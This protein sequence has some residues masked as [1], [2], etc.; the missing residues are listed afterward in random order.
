MQIH[1]E[2][3]SIRVDNFTCTFVHM[4]MFLSDVQEAKDATPKTKELTTKPEYIA[5]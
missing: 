2:A 4:R 5:L 3:L 1:A